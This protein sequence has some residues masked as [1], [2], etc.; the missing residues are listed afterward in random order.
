[1]DGCWQVGAAVIEV[2]HRGSCLWLGFGV[3]GGHPKEMTSQGDDF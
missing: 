2:G 3:P 1:M